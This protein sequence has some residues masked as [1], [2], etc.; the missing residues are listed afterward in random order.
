MLLRGINE[1]LSLCMERHF[2]GRTIKIYLI[3]QTTIGNH[4]DK[5]IKLTDRRIIT[6]VDPDPEV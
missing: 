4:M 5:D 3:D 6:N 1:P 2:N